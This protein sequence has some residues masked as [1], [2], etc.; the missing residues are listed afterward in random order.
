M[1]NRKLNFTSLLKNGNGKKVVIVFG[2]LGM[3]LILISS[4]AD[5]NKK[6]ETAVNYSVQEYR[7]SMQDDLKYILYKI[8]GV[9]DVEVLLT[10]ENSVEGVYLENNSTKTKEI[11]PIIRGVVIACQGGDEPIVK[12][13]VLNATTRA[14]N[15]SSAKVCVT[16]LKE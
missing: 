15:I 4:L 10:I 11:E 9:G 13:R 2:V 16:K 12:E 6:E 3:L 5:F 14:L 8:D 7:I 1:E